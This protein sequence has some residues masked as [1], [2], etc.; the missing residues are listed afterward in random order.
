MLPGATAECFQKVTMPT[1]EADQNTASAQEAPRKQ[2]RRI[3]VRIARVL[4]VLVVLLV[5]LV[6]ALPFLLSL[7]PGRRLAA[8]QLSRRLDRT[9]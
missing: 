8:G 5:L 1:S 2:P 9:V 7:G 4:A 6:L 3:F